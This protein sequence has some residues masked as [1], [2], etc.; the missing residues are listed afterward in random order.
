MTKLQAIMNITAHINNEFNEM[1]N[2]RF[3]DLQAGDGTYSILDDILT[4]YDHFNNIKFTDSEIKLFLD[5]IDEKTD[6]YYY[7]HE[8]D[9]LTIDDK[10]K[11]FQDF[12]SIADGFAEMCADQGI[13]YD[14]PDEWLDWLQ[15]FESNDLTYHEIRYINTLW[16]DENKERHRRVE[17]SKTQMLINIL[18]EFI[19]TCDVHEDVE[20]LKVCNEFID[21]LQQ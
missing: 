6:D 20:L 3:Q 13:N 5:Y 9:D 8:F 7:A 18:N 16:T 19:N 14:D 21:Q 4:V 15:G 10:N 2:D 17:T 11:L 1:T 12:D